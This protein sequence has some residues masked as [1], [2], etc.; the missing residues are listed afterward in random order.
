MLI[1]SEILLVEGNKL[2]SF[3]ELKEC[4]QKT[5]LE[6]GELFFNVDIEPPAYPRSS[7]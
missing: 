7:Q 1:L 6:R 4:L 2:S 5:A 3:E